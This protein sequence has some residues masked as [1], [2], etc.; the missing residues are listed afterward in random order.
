MFSTDLIGKT[1]SPQEED[2]LTGIGTFTNSKG[3]LQAKIP[4]STF[5]LVKIQR[6]FINAG[7]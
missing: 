1:Y 2:V 7:E 3:I 4:W 6:K 5:F